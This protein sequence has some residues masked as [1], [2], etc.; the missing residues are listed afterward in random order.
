MTDKEKECLDKL[1]EAHHAFI[2]LP[3]NDDSTR[4]WVYHIHA[5]QN[6]IM[7]RETARNHPDYF[8]QEI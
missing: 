7:A 8:N 1:V 2:E 3:R 6:L 5:L 4:D